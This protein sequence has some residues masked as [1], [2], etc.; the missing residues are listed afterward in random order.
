MALVAPAGT[1]VQADEGASPMSL[2]PADPAVTFAL[3]E[4][5]EA[6]ANGF[7]SAAAL[8]AAGVSNAQIDIAMNQAVAQGVPQV[9]IDNNDTFAEES[10]T[11]PN[12]VGGADVTDTNSAGFSADFNADASPAWTIVSDWKDKGDRAMVM[13]KGSYN[14]STGYGWG[15][16]KVVGVRISNPSALALSRTPSTSES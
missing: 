12:Y 10:D 15:L 14:S 4:G 3:F 8:Q 16:A 6:D 2:V 11:Y 7:V 5:P 9:S 1:A 13:R